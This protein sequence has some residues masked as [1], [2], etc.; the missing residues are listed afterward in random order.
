MN[1]TVLAFASLKERLGFEQKSVELCEGATLAAALPS[2]LGSQ[3]LF[4]ALKDSTMF[5]INKRYSHLDQELH[6]GDVL[7]II[8]PV[9]GG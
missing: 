3:E 5:A 6:A 4:E 9:A 7:A 1:I 2:I 8:P